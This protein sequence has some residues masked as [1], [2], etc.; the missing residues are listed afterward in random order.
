M[1][2]AGDL[3]TQLT[4]GDQKVQ[5][6]GPR[7]HP[8]LPQV[9]PLRDVLHIQMCSHLPLASGFLFHFLPQTAETV[10]IVPVSRR[11]LVQRTVLA[12]VHSS[13]LPA[14]DH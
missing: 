12:G 9:D 7:L 11:V 14:Q 10:H 1:Y 13:H 5:S 8:F 4:S 2:T 6:S 3:F